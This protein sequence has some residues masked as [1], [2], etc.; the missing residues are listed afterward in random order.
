MTSV[1]IELP[2]DG[3]VVVPIE[4]SGA[5]GWDVGEK[6]TIQLKDGE[7]RIF[8]QTQAILRAQE[9]I[10]GFVTRDR[11]LSNELIAERKQESLS[12]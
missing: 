2:M 11:S 10:S 6:L 5:M 7:I 3:K 8:S 1:E 4:L 9:W 12:E